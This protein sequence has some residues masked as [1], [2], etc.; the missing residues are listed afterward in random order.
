MGLT[1]A[2]NEAAFNTL[3]PKNG[4]YDDYILNAKLILLKDFLLVLPND[5]LCHVIPVKEIA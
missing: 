5:Y 2:T 4:E 3:K 1:I